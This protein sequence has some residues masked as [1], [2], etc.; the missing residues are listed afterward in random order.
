MKYVTLFYTLPTLLFVCYLQYKNWINYRDGNG[1]D[2]QRLF[3]M[4]GSVAAIGSAICNLFNYQDGVSFFLTLVPIVGMGLY[5][6]KK[7]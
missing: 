1:A 7:K 3:L 5:I 2:K 6:L 4:L